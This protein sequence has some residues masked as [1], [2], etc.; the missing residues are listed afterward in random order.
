MRRWAHPRRRDV[1]TARDDRKRCSS[2]PPAK[3]SPRWRASGRPPSEDVTVLAASSPPWCVHR[4]H[5]RSF[6]LDRPSPHGDGNLHPTSSRTSATRTRCIGP[7]RSRHRRATLELGGTIRREHGVGLARN[8]GCA[9]RWRRQF[10]LMRQI[11]HTL[12]PHNVR[13]RQDVR[14]RFAGTR[15][16][17]VASRRPPGKREE[18]AYRCS[19]AEHAARR[20]ASAGHT[21]VIPGGPRT[22]DLPRCRTPRHRLLGTP[23]VHALRHVSPMATTSDRASGT[24]RADGSP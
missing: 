3:R 7:E 5:R 20:D 11:K 24:A 17:S 16:A 6:N 18:R 2:P 1:R 15:V 23:A 8:R 10:G 21:A 9:S 13:I 14:L 19:S 22:K 4:G 12:D